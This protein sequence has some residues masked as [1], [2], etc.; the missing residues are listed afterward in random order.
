MP[1]SAFT[2]FDV[3][4]DDNGTEI[5]LSEVT[6]YV[7][8]VTDADPATGAGAIALDDLESDESGHVVAGTLPVAAG[9]MVRFGWF[10]NVDVR[11]GSAVQTTF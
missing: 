10:R 8:D 1:S 7:R 11:C 9:R 4:I 6:V 2:G 5:L 3:K